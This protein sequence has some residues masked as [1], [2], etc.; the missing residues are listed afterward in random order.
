MRRTAGSAAVFVMPGP[1]PAFH[2]TL[3]QRQLF[4]ALLLRMDDDHREEARRI[5][6]SGGVQNL[7]SLSGGRMLSAQVTGGK[8]Y[9]V[10]IV[11]P[12]NFVEVICRCGA[13]TGACVH[14]AAV[15]MEA[16]RERRQ[17]AA[18][19]AAGPALLDLLVQHGGKKL[20]KTTERFLSGVQEWW[21]QRRQQLESW[22]FAGV[23]GGGSYDNYGYQPVE[24]YPE[25]LPPRDAWEF[26]TGIVVLMRQRKIVPPKPVAEVIGA[27]AI[28]AL[29]TKWRRHTEVA[30]WRH[31]LH[32]WRGEAAAES[33]GSSE[34]RLRLHDSGA[35][36]QICRPGE[37]AFSRATQKQLK[38][39]APRQYYSD[40]AGAA[41]SAG[42]ASVIGAADSYGACSPDVPPMSSSLSTSLTRLLTSAELFAKH[43]AGPDG[44][45]LLQPEEPLRWELSEPPD[46]DGDGDYELRLL[47]A[48]G[49]PVP[50]PAAILS[51]APLR[52]VTPQAVYALPAWPFGKER[53]SWPAR[54]PAAALETSEG[55]RALGRMGLPV[56]QRLEGR[57]RHVHSKVTVLCK[58]QRYQHSTSDYFNLRAHAKAE[59]SGEPAK[60]WNGTDWQTPPHAPPQNDSGLVQVDASAQ[61]TAAPWLRR[62]TL[63]PAYQYGDMW[64][65]QR[66]QTKDWPELFLAWLKDKP[67]GVAVE[68]DPELAGLE[69]GTVAGSVRLDVEESPSGIDWFDLKVAL[70]ISDTSLTPEEIALLLKSSGRW[71]RLEGKGWRKLQFNLTPEQEEQ[72]A[73]LGLSPAQLQGEKQKMHA[74]QLAGLAKKDTS[75][76]PAE[77][78]FK[79]QRRLE[80]IQTRVAPP[81]PKEVK[82]ELRPYQTA[83][84]QFLAY[85]STNG[86]GGVLADDMG[87]GKTLQALT[88]IA[89]LR[90]AQ[91]LNAPVLV[92]CPKSVQENWRAEARKFY[93]KLPVTVWDRGRA[94]SEGL[95]GDFRLVVI[96]YQQMRQH[97][98]LLRE[99]HWGAII[100]DEAQAIKNPAS[101]NSVT[102]RGF[103]AK[104]RLALTG[105][106]VE[107]RLLDLWSIFAFAMPG[108]LGNKASFTK[109]FDAK[110]DPLARRRLA[111]RTRPFLL[112][113]NKKEVASDLPDRIEE[114]IVVELDGAQ[115]T[116]Y[117]AELK[118]ARAQLL[119]VATDRQLDKLRFNILT[120]LLRLRQICCHPR[121]L[122]GDEPDSAKVSALM[123][124]LEPLMEEG[125]KVLVFSQ[126]VTMLDIIEAELTA[127][128]WTFF[129]LTGD[130]E[131]R[132]ALVDR[133]QNHDG[134][135]VFL[136]SLKAG[137]FGLNLTAASYVVLFDPWW[138]PAVEAQAID[139]THRIGQQQTVFAY[140][141][142]VKDTIE[143][144]IRQLQKRKGALAQDVL[145]EE[146]FAQALS[147]SDFQFL[148]GDA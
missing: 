52:Y 66:I 107:N 60:H 25:A 122:G 109:H 5:Y 92:V 91:K 114:D 110:D 19:P 117:Q 47:D 9:P 71:V 113:R 145:G 126:F 135:A 15:L 2:L 98:D 54:I 132:G 100:L 38:E 137:G 106:P 87:L 105:T 37:A 104:H 53:M 13:H 133:F 68:L 41:L 55:V 138:N 76:L 69:Q 119:K 63:R 40:S 21:D 130:T 83:G 134:P 12:G 129:K 112:R 74:L 124:H 22:R 116:L 62:L 115:H 144:K 93:P 140:R 84:F 80:E 20:T 16:L 23:C 39:L 59:G 85:L 97:A 121:L 141:L 67:D 1:V 46:G 70:D 51:G 8:V 136:I 45:P 131:D 48:G 6:E 77:R 89:W 94:G 120:S 95:D 11:I 103:I 27:E 33:F 3:T 34:L 49:A 88:W 36:I 35:E 146:S 58:L 28:I 75:L 148:L 57:V 14:A 81:Q 72:L 43:V 111:A 73:D 10:M 32:N 127:R 96:H 17:G 65:E 78:A 128:G 86:F 147:L 82:A 99:V 4:Q 31:T 143:E 56:P 61:L 29:E 123:E 44:E 142:I 102:A 118:R 64:L 42:S 24:L 18:P 139:R 101:Q 26:L 50:P 90:T 30:K 125:Q 108:V 79:L 7:R